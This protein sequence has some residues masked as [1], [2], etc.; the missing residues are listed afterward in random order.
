MFTVTYNIT[1]EDG[2]LLSSRAT[3][4]PS[5]RKGELRAENFDLVIT[6]DRMDIMDAV[7]ETPILV[8]LMGSAFAKDHGSDYVLRFPRLIKVHTDR[9]WT[10]GVSKDEL[11]E[12]AL[13]AI[14]VGNEQEKERWENALGMV[15]RHH[16]ASGSVVPSASLREKTREEQRGSINIGRYGVEMEFG[17]D[18]E[19]IL[20]RGFT[21]G[22]RKRTESNATEENKENI[23]PAKKRRG[24]S[25]NS[26]PLPQ[27]YP[28]KSRQVDNVMPLVGMKGQS[29]KLGIARNDRWANWFAE[30]DLKPVL[31]DID[32]YLD[33]NLLLQYVKSELNIDSASRIDMCVEGGEKLIRNV[34]LA[35]KKASQICD[36]R[37]SVY[38]SRAATPHNYTCSESHRLW[39]YINGTAH[40]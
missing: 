27:K 23:E 3:S 8:E 19:G 39:T 13:S 4:I 11:Q 28:L 1:R 15:D 5:T 9:H 18:V 12:A 21:L 31:V 30:S 24:P 16:L 17:L 34:L 7:F 32:D 29:V 10:E 37:W 36:G 40:R 33:E 22:K 20:S 2:L 14:A 6:S 35:A 25:S 38:F 26:L